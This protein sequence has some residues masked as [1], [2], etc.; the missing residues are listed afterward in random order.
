MDFAMKRAGKCP[1]KIRTLF[2]HRQAES[3]SLL[4]EL[5]DL[6]QQISAVNS[7]FDILTDEEL[8]SACCFQMKALSTRYDRLLREA[9][10]RGLHQEPYGLPPFSSR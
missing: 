3:D 9:R 1:G 7:Q 6:Q 4:E 2:F 8:I 5:A 10:L